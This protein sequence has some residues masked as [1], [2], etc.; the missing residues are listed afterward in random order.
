MD[1]KKNPE[2]PFAVTISKDKMEVFLELK[3]PGIEFT[4]EDLDCVFTE[5]ENLGIYINS[6]DDLCDVITSGTS[7][8]SLSIAKGLLPQNGIDGYCEI[9]C[10]NNT[11]GRPN[12]RE[13]GKV[14]FYNI[15]YVTNVMEG[16]ILATIH[17]PKEGKDGTDVFGNKIPYKPGK[18]AKVPVGKNTSLNEEKQEIFATIAG[19]VSFAENQINVHEVLEIKNVDFKTGNIDFIGSVVVTE[20]VKDGFTVKA[21]GDVTVKG[22]VDSSYIFCGGNLVVNGGIQGRNKGIVQAGGNVIAR[23]IENCEIKSGGSVSVKDAI[24]H[25][26]VYAKEKVVASEGKGLIVGGVIG[27]GREIIANTI[28]S[29]LATQTELEVGVNPDLRERLQKL[30][31]ELNSQNEDLKKAKQAQRLLK[32]KEDQQGTLPSAQKSMLIRLNITINHLEKTLEKNKVI[33]QQMLEKLMSSSGGKVKAFKQVYPGVK[34]TIGTRY[35]NITDTLTAPT[36][37]IGADGEVTFA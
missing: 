12:I 23:Y 24:M 11:Q 2:L 21:V 29:H 32:L 34:I 15:E 36:F 16:E 8:D 33:Q 35:R 1:T 5:I 14:D 4:K 10:E 28:G 17:P 18:S 20:G 7:L 22:Y 31:K 30:T 3:K 9:H 25:S 13:D 26:R 37:V 6:K 19:Q 27:C